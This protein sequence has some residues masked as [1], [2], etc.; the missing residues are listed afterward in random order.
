MALSKGL[1]GKV[2]NFGGNCEL[3]NNN[4]IK[5][6]ASVMTVEMGYSNLNFL[7]ERVEDRPGHDFRYSIDNK[8]VKES[9]GW[10]PKIPLTVACC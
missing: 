5:Q 6:I 8:E 1:P 10:Q 9:L 3:S 7:V 4:I 2:Y